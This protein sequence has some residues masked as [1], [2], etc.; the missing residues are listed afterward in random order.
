MIDL[1]DVD[2]YAKALAPVFKRAIKRATDDLM[3][4]FEREVSARDQR[5]ARLEGEIEGFRSLSVDDIARRAAEMVPRPDPAP[6]VADVLGAAGVIRDAAREAV[7]DYIRAHPVQHG[8]D[9]DPG[10]PGPPGPR[11]PEGPPGRDGADGV[12][13]AGAVID[14]NGCLVI[15]TTR[16]DVIPL[17][18]VIGEPGKDGVDGSPGKDG[19]DGLGFDDI[20]LVETE[21]HVA[22]R[23]ERGDA[24]R[25]FLLPAFIYRGTYS[26]GTYYAKGNGATWGGSLWIAK[27]DGH[28]GAPGTGSADWQLAV[29]KG[30]DG[31]DGRNGI[32]KTTPVKS[33][34]E[35]RNP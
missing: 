18:R 11:G 1:R 19:M 33:D 25:E 9:G 23:F 29:K 5:I 31:K 30:R 15:T 21:S 34:D 27:K 6:S 32:D 22:L 13:I 35:P 10:P 16:G 4:H 2:A 24:S 28:L 14:K 26:A 20:E 17:G 8:K 12:G 7:N 3:S